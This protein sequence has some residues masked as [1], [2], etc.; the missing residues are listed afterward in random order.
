MSPVSCDCVWVVF[1]RP[2]FLP[3]LCRDRG[4]VGGGVFTTI[5]I[6]L[7]L[8]DAPGELGCDPPAEFVHW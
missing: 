1:R 7:Y 4:T 8:Y 6:P 2:H 5:T 3:S